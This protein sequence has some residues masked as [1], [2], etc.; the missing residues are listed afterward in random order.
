MTFR[1]EQ[2]GDCR[3]GRAAFLAHVARLAETDQ[4]IQPVCLVGVIEQPVG[5]DVVDGDRRPLDRAAMLASPA[6]AFDR[7]RSRRWP[8]LAPVCGDAADIVRRVLPGLLAHLEG[9]VASLGAET[10]SGLRGVLAFKPWLNLKLA[11]AVTAWVD[12]A[13]HRVDLSRPLRRESV[14][15]AQAASPLVSRLVIIRHFPIGHVPFAAASVAAKPG[16]RRPVRLN[17]ERFGTDFANLLDHA[18]SIAW[19]AR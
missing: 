13:L 2:I 11:P 15:R 16:R 14:R 4:I 18:D 1:E 10:A 19:G 5:P 6:V 7:S 3:S 8:A 9:R 17:G 12:S